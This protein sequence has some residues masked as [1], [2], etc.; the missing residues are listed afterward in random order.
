MSSL[1]THEMVLLHPKTQRLHYLEKNITF[2][3]SIFQQECIITSLTLT[4]QG[5]PYSEH[6]II[7]WFNECNTTDAECSH[8]IPL[9]VT[10]AQRIQTTLENLKVPFQRNSNSYKRLRLTV[11]YLDLAAM[12]GRG[13]SI[14][15]FTMAD[16][17]R[18][19]EAGDCTIYTDAILLSCETGSAAIWGHSPKAPSG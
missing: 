10:L 4:Y 16:A 3:F 6:Q 13:N 12:L 15:K 1:E 11:E 7:A 17:W 8:K 5:N 9:I 2:F 19:K 18:P 14:S